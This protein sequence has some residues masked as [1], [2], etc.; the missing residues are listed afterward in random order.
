MSHHSGIRASGSGTGDFIKK[1]VLKD[2]ASYGP[3][4]AKITSILDAEDLWELVN[5]TELEPE[6][7]DS[8]EDN[9]DVL[10]DNK[11]EVLERENEIKA[12]KKR[13][14][15]A[16]SLITQTV[17]DSIV[18]SLDVHHRNPCLMWTQLAADY[19]TVTPA[20]RTIAR[21][22]FQNFFI[23]EDETY[24]ECKQKFNELLRLITA[25]GGRVSM[26]DQLQTL[27]GALPEKFDALRESYFAQT[28]EPSID[29][30]WDRMFDIETTQIR[31]SSQAVSTRAEGYFQTRGRGSGTFRGRSRGG[32]RGGGSGRNSNEAKSENCFRCGDADHWSRECPQKDSMCTWCGALGHIEKTCYSK[33]N[34][35]ARGG[36]SGGGRGRGSGSSGRGRGGG[37]TRYG[38]GEEEEEEQ[39]HAEVLVGEV[40][41]GSG[42]GDGDEK[43]WVCDSGADF[44][45][46]GDK[47]LFDIIA[48]IPSTFFVKQIKG[49]VSVTQWGVVR[50]STDGAGGKKRE[51]ELREVL[52]MPGM[53]VNIFSLQRI[54][55]KGACSYTFQGV[56]NP[57]GV[58][59]I[60]NKGGVQI[61]TMRET[62]KARPT[63]V[64]TR[65]H[66]VDSHGGDMEGEVLGGKGVQ[67]DLL[68]R[69]LGH[70]SQSVMERLVREQ[71]VRGLEEGVKGE[72]GM[73]RGCKMGRSSENNHP[74]K[75]SEFRAK[76]PLELIHTDIAG[77]FEPKAIGGGGKYNLVIIDDFSRKSWTI[78]LRL[79][80]DTKV[81]LK[82]WIAVRENEVGKRVKVMRSDNGGE[83]IDASLETWLKEHGITHQTI[84]ARSP[85]S[86]GVAER[87][88]RTLQDRARSM[89]VG[90]GLGG[91]FWAEAI[92][93]A[94]YIRNRGPVAGLSKTPDELWSGR[95]P[96]IK[97][98]KAY[99][100]KAY[101]S[102]EKW[103]RKG[104]MGVTKW[105]GV[106]VGYPIGSVGYRVWDPV[107]GKV[108]NVG[109]PHVDEDV[110]PG[111]WRKDTSQGGDE[112]N[113]VILFPD[114]NVDNAQVAVEVEEVPQEVE[115]QL[116]D[117][118]EDSSDD[119][120]EGDGA[121]GGDDDEWGPAD[122]APVNPVHGG[123]PEGGAVDVDDAAQLNEPRHSNRERRGVPPLRFIEMY[124]AS[125][126]EEEIKQSPKTVQEAL[127][128][129]HGEKWQKAMD[130]EMQSLR[131]NGVY[132]IVDRP[133]GKKVVKSK[134]VLRVKTNEKGE[135]EKYKARVVA[136][137]FSQVEGVDY[138]QTFSPTVR[139]ES[140]RQM[141]ALGTAK[142]MEMH[143]MDVTT[144]FLYAPLEEDI[145]MEQPE[146]TVQKGDERKVMR[147]LKCL[148]G[149]KQSPRQWNIYI[150][151]VLKQL[152][153]RRLKSDFGIYVKGEGEDAVY[154]ALYVDDL[155]LVGRKLSNIEVVKRG[156]HE[157]F[158]MKDL[159]EAK[160]LLGIE[161]RRQKNGDV[162][163]VQERY[164]RDVI[165]RFN[166]E[167]CKPVSTP[168]DLGCHLDNTQQPVTD[169]ERAEMVDVPYRSAIGSL[170]YLATC[171]RPD[172]AAA[173][174]E[175]SKF[176]QNPGSA[177]WEGVKR[178]LRYVN[179]TVGDGLM[180]RRGAQVEVWGYSDAGHAGDRETS[181]GRTGY[182][183]LSAGAAI[184]WRSS[185]M[186]LVTHSS[187]E[188]EYVGLSEA[189]NEAVYLQQLQGE[190]C[191]G[192]T[193][194]LLLG[195]NE[196]SL[197]LAMNPVF[198][199]RSKHIRIKYHSLRDR[200]EEG[201]LELCKVDTGLNA[202]DMMTKNV[203]VGVLKMCKGLIGMVGSG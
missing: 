150:D 142:S 141:V 76:E 80:S 181:R 114:L 170:M 14:K 165:S 96:S 193:S 39:G 46:T 2:A 163:L 48:P 160:F 162:F 197:K 32:N 128:G 7:I 23:S 119:E 115:P 19:N 131:E 146:G 34:G 28:P 186:K 64:C 147:L 194:V 136:K 55:H 63:L 154:I 94:S 35:S 149:L 6:E 68:H 110:Q 144:A 16:A 116:P 179:G 30:I 157:E 79:K 132:E 12:W 74:R 129:L 166:M 155:F 109:V 138:D 73:C 151:T 175:L 1:I 62:T 86:N 123:M 196:S 71:M 198:H 171:T 51:L 65:L 183:F 47:S 145:Y 89:L 20:R 152:G 189:G 24:L 167:G 99:G 124:L 45:M 54:R 111:W 120:D 56:P 61:A 70:T 164:A 27:L 106:I 191:I 43:E 134:W 201:L 33:A 37:Y 135:I 184:S 60:L 139:F 187:C 105:E 17:D 42:D 161:I 168:L 18:M 8:V 72:F 100:S 178:V 15:K 137:G 195:D 66:E 112:E 41:M 108:Y 182:V 97:H 101:V 38:E 140:I 127:E 143:Q 103:K 50:L 29:Y 58:I 21:K 5:G 202:A 81:A 180:Y 126:A 158:K 78:P 36:K 10:P 172:I 174:S 91:G 11:A 85:Q 25:Q 190:M 188:S 77:P 26:A 173:V 69:R 67:M 52:F 148:Y 177:H 153:F 156:L 83:Y 87:M 75:D 49:K 104:K 84:P 125:A 200:V 88:N 199:Q 59:P 133:A 9:D 98:L 4:R 122:D 118:V 13:A 117:L 93:T 113:E 176:S 82:Q 53:K 57:E 169:A 121:G 107:R 159:G 203:G 130:S 92:S 31:R 185:M 90:A 40:N 44:H 3:W 95:V 22:D 192:K 102:L